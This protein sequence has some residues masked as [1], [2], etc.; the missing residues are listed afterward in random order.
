MSSLFGMIHM[1]ASALMANQT[2]VNLIGN[3][4]ANVNTEGYSRQR[5]SMVE[6]PPNYGGI[7]GLQPT[8]M[9][10]KSVDRVRDDFLDAQIRLFT[11]D[12]GYFE[13]LGQ[14]YESMETL[15]RGELSNIDASAGA[16]AAS[17]SDVLQSF[18]N[19]FQQLSN[20]PESLPV[21][22]AARQ[23]SITL[24]DSFHDMDM[25]MGQLR[26]D[27]DTEVANMVNEANGYL[28]HIADLNATIVAAESDGVTNANGLRDE[29]DLM[30]NKLAE[31]VPITY[32]ESSDHSV[33]VN[34]RGSTLVDHQNANLF[35]MVR[36]PNDST[37]WLEIYTQREQ[38]RALTRDFYAGKLGGVLKS[39][40]EVVG[41]YRARLSNLA[42]TLI[43]EVNRFHTQGTGLKEFT[44]TSSSV[45]LP[46]DVQPVG[47]F[48]V[49]FPAQNGSFVLRLSDPYGV[50]Q[51]RFRIDIDPAVDSLSAI[52]AR[53]DA[54]DGVPGGGNLTATSTA[55]QLKIQTNNGY[56]FGFETDSAN[57]LR[58]M[59]INTFFKG[60]NA[61][62][63][64]LSDLVSDESTGL[65]MMAMS[66][67]G[68]PGD[69]GGALNIASLAYLP[70][71][72]NNRSSIPDL[73]RSMMADVGAVGERVK[74]QAHQADRITQEAID[75]Q[76]AI[77]GVN[78]DE[79]SVSLIQYQNAYTAC[80]RFVTTVDTL[81]DVVINRLGTG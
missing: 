7:P 26:K 74:L 9:M 39:R 61:A 65:E 77:A 50:V 47:A 15:L 2:V 58:M 30:L 1:G 5:A 27:L 70:V 79:E 51:N 28:Q 71:S 49:D 8:G 19:A 37:G 23:A 44:S 78:M 48:T 40:D 57:F 14:G 46:N 76:D 66:A 41:V 52:A 18:F 12:R 75:R 25:Q 55:G 17:F 34:F 42:N 16:T 56:T 67:N 69:A 24:L 54:L 20:N 31:I 68:A 36:E 35:S 3:N 73:F 59:G 80:A 62:D 11:S 33:V 13:A 72:Q 22:A 29:R 60:T 45:L 21:R 32:Q 6:A 10:L 63:I 64:D 81:L 38:T 53:I 4:I 43:G